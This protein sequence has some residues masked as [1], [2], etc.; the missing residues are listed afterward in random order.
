MKNVR[1]F[2]ISLVVIAVALFFLSFYFFGKNLTNPVLEDKFIPF[3]ALYIYNLEPSG[4]V[5][6]NFFNILIFSVLLNIPI[7]IIL[8]GLG[9]FISKK[10]EE[11]GRI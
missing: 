5:G 11:K 8:K 6:I 1:L 2:S 10:L 3:E 4:E 7:F 9:S